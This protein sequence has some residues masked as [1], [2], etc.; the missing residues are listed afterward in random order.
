MT[1]KPKTMNLK[2][3]I[4]KDLSANNHSIHPVKYKTNHKHAFFANKSNNSTSTKTTTT[5]T[6]SSSTQYSAIKEVFDKNPI[7]FHFHHSFR[8]TLELSQR[9]SAKTLK[10]SS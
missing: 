4:R 9:A 5:L 1:T 2:N 3:Y 6:T 8:K 7:Q 10:E